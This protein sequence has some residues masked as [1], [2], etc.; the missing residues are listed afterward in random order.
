M[1]KQEK[2]EAFFPAFLQFERYC[3]LVLQE[4]LYEGAEYDTEEQKQ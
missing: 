1:K 3:V 4:L 2:G